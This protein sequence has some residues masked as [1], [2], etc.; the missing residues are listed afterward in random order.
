MS[1]L[2]LPNENLLRETPDKGLQEKALVYVAQLMW[3]IITCNLKFAPTL[4]QSP[5]IFQI[6]LQLS[7]KSLKRNSAVNQTKV[8]LS[9][10]PINWNLKYIL[11]LCMSFK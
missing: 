8:P 5:V 9:Q 7:L 10:E 4:N 6:G 11:N 1:I 2:K 3:E